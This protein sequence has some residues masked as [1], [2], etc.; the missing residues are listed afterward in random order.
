L[1]WDCRYEG[2]IV[3][4]AFFAEHEEETLEMLSQWMGSDG[5][6][7]LDKKGWGAWPGEENER[8]VHKWLGQSVVW[9]GISVPRILQ[10]FCRL[11]EDYEDRCEEMRSKG[12]L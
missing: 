9:F 8:V 1:D 2:V 6:T 11:A 4:E 5:I 12:W 10:V 7:L 3:A